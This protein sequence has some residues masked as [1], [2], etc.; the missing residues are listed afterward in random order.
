ME[1]RRRDFR[2]HV[3]AARNMETVVEVMN[4]VR[5]VQEKHK[6]SDV[7]SD[8]EHDL[9]LSLLDAED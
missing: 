2:E 3:E 4:M 7:S 1:A 5:K 6:D 8:G 9:G